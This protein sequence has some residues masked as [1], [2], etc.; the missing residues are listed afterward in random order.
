[1][2]N[3]FVRISNKRKII[4]LCVR[5][6]RFRE[7]KAEVGISDA[8][9][10]K[11]LKELQKLGWLTWKQ[12]RYKLTTAGRKVLPQA[13]VAESLLTLN[14]KVSPILVKNVTVNHEGLE[15]EDAETLLSDIAQATDRYLTKH[16]GKPITLVVHY[17]GPG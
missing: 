7:L 3:V 6:M 5:P 16:S 11:D 12:D 8:G 2:A 13:Q 15:G 10:S 4:Q 9:L 17:S 1:M 14:F